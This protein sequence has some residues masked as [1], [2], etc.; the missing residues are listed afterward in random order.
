MA[1]IKKRNKWMA[2]GGLLAVVL[3]AVVL[4]GCMP[5]KMVNWQPLDITNTLSTDV[6]SKRW[7]TYR[8][9]TA[10][11][12]PYQR[13]GYVMFADDVTMDMWK[14]PY[15]NL[16]KKSMREVLEDHDAYLKS[17]MWTGTV[18]NFKRY[19]LEGNAIAYT[20]NEL[21]MEVDLWDTGASGSNIG[22]RL[23]YTDRRSFSGGDSGSGMDGQGH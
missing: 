2:S 19:E 8:F 13:I 21:E 15:A 9:E 22:L 20:A 6:G 17:R 12:F 10:G 11:P 7:N 14:V 23:T 5:A 1:N 18:M 4:G 3:S 16:G